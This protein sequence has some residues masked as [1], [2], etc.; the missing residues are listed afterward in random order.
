MDIENGRF[1]V[2]IEFVSVAAYMKRRV[3]E[4]RPRS[5]DRRRAS[6]RSTTPR[7]VT[8]ADVAQLGTISIDNHY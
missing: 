6:M 2:S 1:R 7:Q 3:D 5:V 8:A 4:D